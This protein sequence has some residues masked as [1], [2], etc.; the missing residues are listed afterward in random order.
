MSFINFKVSDKKKSDYG[1]W[2]SRHVPPSI[3]KNRTEKHPELT[4]LHYF[5][6]DIHKNFQK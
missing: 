3:S 6:I 5:E 1:T 4:S 2:A